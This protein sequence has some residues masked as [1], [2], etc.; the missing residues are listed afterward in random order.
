MNIRE[1]LSSLVKRRRKE[2]REE[3][4]REERNREEGKREEGRG[5]KKTRRVE[6][7]SRGREDW[8]GDS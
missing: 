4:N 3:R 5:E 1:C 8:R 2:R 7:K 6:K